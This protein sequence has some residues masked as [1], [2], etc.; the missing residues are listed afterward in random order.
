MRAILGWGLSIVTRLKQAL[1]CH[2]IKAQLHVFIS[3]CQIHKT[4]LVQTRMVENG[5]TTSARITR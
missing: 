1:N 5:M 3:Q 4:R 2:L